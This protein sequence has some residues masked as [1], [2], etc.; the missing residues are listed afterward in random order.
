MQVKNWA[1]DY[2]YICSHSLWRKEIHYLGSIKVCYGN[3]EFKQLI[4]QMFIIFTIIREALE[5]EDEKIEV[6]ILKMLGYIWKENKRT[7]NTHTIFPTPQFSKKIWF[8]IMLFKVN[9]KKRI[10]LY[11]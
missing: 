8:C 4:Y 1:K 6:N 11:T 7:V 2:K 10:W 9:Q 3:L 5:N